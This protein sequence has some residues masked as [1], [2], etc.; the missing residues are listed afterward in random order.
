[1]IF[2]MQYKPDTAVGLSVS[3]GYRP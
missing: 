2:V 3:T 1:M